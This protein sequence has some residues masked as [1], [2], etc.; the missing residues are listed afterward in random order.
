MRV[1]ESDSATS[2]RD[3][4]AASERNASGFEARFI[5]WVQRPTLTRWLGVLALLLATPSLFIGFYLDDYIGRYI[6]SNLPG[7]QRL[8]DLY[9]RGYGLA[10]GNLVDN[11]WQIEAGHAPW[12]IYPQLRL[13]L[14]RPL[15]LWTHLLDAR[16]WPDNALLMHAQSVLWLLL[17]VLA[18][19]RFYRGLCGPLI[20]GVAALLL[21]LDHTHGF[22]VG[23]ICNRH[24]LVT[25]T[26]G[27][28]CLEQ[29]RRSHQRHS[30][31]ARA[32]ALALYLATLLASEAGLA[33]GGYLFA[34]ALCIETGSW[35]ARARSFAPYL[36]VTVLWRIAYNH[37]G[38]GGFGSGIYLDPGREPLRF[39]AAALERIPFLCLGQF[40]IPPAELYPQYSPFALHAVWLSGVLFIGLFIWALW[41]SL[42]TQRIA[43]FWALAFA[44]SLVPAS[45][46]APH[47]R[48]LLLSSLAAMGLLAQLW[49]LIAIELRA[50]HA[51]LRY[52]LAGTLGGS[53]LFVHLYCS[54]FFLP[55]TT[56]SVALAA[57][58]HRAADDIGSEI[59]GK[60][61]VFVSAP[62]Y[63]AVRL[64]QIRKRIDRQP[65]ARRWRAL[66]FGPRG[67]SI[68][69]SDARTLLIDYPG[70][71][72]Q[73][74]M[75][76]LFRDRRLRMQRG[77]R[78]ELEGLT[79][80]VLRLTADGRA[81][82]VRFAFSD[83][84]DSTQFIFYRWKDGENG[85]QRFVLP[86]PGQHIWVPPARFDI[87]NKKDLAQT[88]REIWRALRFQSRVSAPAA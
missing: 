49:H 74:Q 72:L 4:D 35:R 21:T 42:R 56:C 64:V 73:D 36:V 62:E 88:F 53:M 65:L 17:F 39:L 86:E 43:R 57:P 33:I 84:L 45:A 16:L 37:A 2:V 27:V 14:Y 79:I 51:S 34:Y 28:L 7:A 68:E 58:M 46:T 71:I 6:Y 48:Q 25:A 67:F 60:D 77:E 55:L 50:Q 10:N 1:N 54:A 3:I 31:L 47:S 13:V 80:E 41:P 59:A 19:A 40:L 24:A 70:G 66:A 5:A 63:F 52:K 12:W 75:L 18:A 15:S 32:S 85:F 11:H 30:T 26:L 38:Y 76:E 20:G 44:I 82:Q 22:V 23:F 83:S 9:G 29:H 87:W 81:A 69:R 61:V 78:I 8:F